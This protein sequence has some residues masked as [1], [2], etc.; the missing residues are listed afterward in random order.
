MRLH[1][2]HAIL[3]ACACASACSCC[4]AT[5]PAR[6]DDPA[7]TLSPAEQRAACEKA[8]ARLVEKKCKEARPD[9]ADFCMNTLEAGIPLKPLCLA[10]IQECSEIDG[11]C[12]K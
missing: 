10:E 7:L 8:G 9:F 1:R 2:L 5:P 6:T 4:H 3:C 12:R 11:K